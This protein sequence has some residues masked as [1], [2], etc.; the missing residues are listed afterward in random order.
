MEKSLS[1]SVFAKA[2]RI[3]ERKRQACLKT[4]AAVSSSYVWGE[5]FVA[6][7]KSNLCSTF[8][9]HPARDH[10]RAEAQVHS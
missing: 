10:L 1:L 9:T 6:F 2:F 7:T 8:E 3:H 4:S 5:A